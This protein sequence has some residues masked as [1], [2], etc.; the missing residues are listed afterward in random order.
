MPITTSSD[1]AP[2]RER[3]HYDFRECTYAKGWAQIDT[4]QDASYFG[5]WTSPTERK[6]LTYCEGDITI[7]SADTDAEYVQ[8]VRECIGY[9]E[10]AAIDASS[11]KHRFVALG[12]EEVLH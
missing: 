5:I 6:I 4:W 8:I 3:Y 7:Q 2:M 9:Y 10:G 11:L 12:L 1:F